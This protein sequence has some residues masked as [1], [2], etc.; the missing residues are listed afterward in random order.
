M[1][2]RYRWKITPSAI[3]G[4]DNRLAMFPRLQQRMLTNR[5]IFDR[6]E[7]FTYLRQSGPLHS[8]FL[9]DGMDAAVTA[10]SHVI[11]SRQKIA[12]YGDYDVDGVTAS[13]LL[14]QALSVLGADVI[15]Y[16]PNRFEEGYGVNFDALKSLAEGGVSLTITVDCGIR[17]PK[18][19]SYAKS[20]G[21]EMIITD[22]HEPGEEIPAAVAVIC[23]K[24]PGDS[25]PYKHL[26]GVGLAFKL[27]DALMKSHPAAECDARQWLD[28]VAIGSVADIV[29]LTGENRSLVKS[30]LDLL[31]TTSRPAVQALAAVSRITQTQINSGTIGFRFGPRLNAAGRLETADQAFRLMMSETADEALAYAI[32]LDDKN[33]QRQEITRQMQALAMDQI[34]AEALPSV[35]ASASNAYNRG[36]V[37]LAASKLAEHYYRPAIVGS[38]DGGMIHASCRSIDEFNM[39]KALDRCADL[40]VKY[41]GHAMAAGLTVSKENWEPLIERMNAIAEEELA[42]IT[43]IPSLTVEMAISLDYLSGSL[44][45][46]IAEFEP[47][48][49]E[50]DEP[51]FLIC[52]VRTENARIVGKGREHLSLKLRSDKAVIDAVAFRQADRFQELPESIDVIGKFN[53]NVYRGQ[54]TLQLTIQDMRTAGETS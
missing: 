33:R 27:A 35:A 19:V 43:L 37:G 2:Q 42:G 45:E 40:M 41:G 16:I 13:A 39:V 36:I 34:G 8:P 7:A 6:D 38:I 25:Y 52:N 30:G 51:S 12:V 14:I 24:K 29:P 49:T 21:M 54:E 22:H 44:L 18:E 46:E 31:R 10:I 1:Q 9:L 32:Q 26:A 53:K 28:L 11:K 5:G 15:S 20:L 4:T 3:N 47:F 23:P 48:G 50:N 17:S